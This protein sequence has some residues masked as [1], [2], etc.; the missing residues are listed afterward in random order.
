MIQEATNQG[1]LHRTKEYFSCVGKII[2]PLNTAGT[3]DRARWRFAFRTGPYLHAC[4]AVVCMVPTSND[5]LYS[6][7][8]TQS[9]LII[10]SDT[11]ETTAVA[12][13]VFTYGTHPLGT[14][15]DNY[16]WQHVKVIHGY[17]DGLSANTQYYAKFVD[18]NG[19]IL[20]SACVFELQSMT[21]NFSGYLSQNITA[22]TEIY[23]VY[24]QNVTTLQKNLWKQSGAKVLNWTR[25]DGTSPRTVTP[26][27]PTNLIDTSTTY[28]AAIPGFT[29]E[30]TGKARLSQTSGVPVT[31]KVYASN[32]GGG[33]KVNLRDSNGSSVLEVSVSGAAAWSS[34]TGNLPASSAKYYLTANADLGDGS[35][36]ISVY[37]VSIYEYDA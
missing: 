20:Q 23:D 16:S 2:E 31:M 17:I 25:D 35:D 27:T 19:G 13:S 22:Q 21:E 1:A 18:M 7:N 9:K 34:V 29:L 10:Y 15:G 4:Y 14:S 28:G 24:R 30:M 8:N 26:L 6:T 33:G 11:A 5:L 36:P 3:S 37:A 32:S 12:T